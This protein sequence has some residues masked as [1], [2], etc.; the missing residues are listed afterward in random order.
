[1]D[2]ASQLKNLAP[3]LDTHLLYHLL[4]HNATTQSVE[5]RNQIKAKWLSANKTQAATLE[6]NAA[7]KA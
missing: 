4:K 6:T 1:M 3:F 7:A 5:L 2:A